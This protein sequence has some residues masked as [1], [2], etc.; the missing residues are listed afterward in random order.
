MENKHIMRAYIQKYGLAFIL[1]FLLIP[2]VVQGQQPIDSMVYTVYE[3]QYIFPCR[4]AT[5][6][7]LFK[8]AKLYVSPENGYWGDV[9]GVPYDGKPGAASVKERPYTNGNIFNPPVSVADTGIYRFYF[10]FTSSRGYCGIKNNTRFV[11]NLYLGTYGCLEP[12][13][14]GELDQRHYFCFGSNIDM[15]MLG[16]HE[17]D[18]PV[19]IADLLMKYSKNPVDWKQN[20]MLDADWVDMDVYSDRDHKNWIGNGKMEIDLSPASGSYDTTLYVIIHQSGNRE[21]TDSVSI[22]VYPQSKLEIFYSPD[23]RDA[24]REYDMDDQITIT[25]QDSSLFNYYTFLLNNQNLNK[26]YLGGD[27]TKNEITLSALAFSGV[28]DFI[29]IIATDKNN[30]IARAEDNVIVRV[31]FPTVFTPDGD[32]INDI[33]LGGEKFRNREFH[34]EVFSRWEGRLYY[35]E[36]GWDGTHRGNPVPPGTYLYTLIIKTADGSTKTIKGTVTLIRQA[37]K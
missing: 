16:R 20:R 8:A 9:Y 28:E 5:P 10:Y 12:S 4:K 19:T 18:T 32:G 23:I 30:C 14:T 6:I 1:L 29:E 37:S 21:Y 34:L 25:A 36:S 17:F 31:P 11:L 35:G 24:N 27:T 15:N 7:D 13:P 26:Y 3:E 22:R 33:F 2:G